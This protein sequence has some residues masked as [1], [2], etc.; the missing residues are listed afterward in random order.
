MILRQQ[1]EWDEYVGLFTTTVDAID[2]LTDNTEPWFDPTYYHNVGEPDN[3]EEATDWVTIGNLPDPTDGITTTAV[4]SGAGTYSASYEKKLTFTKNAIFK[5][6][7]LKH[8]LIAT[9][10][11]DLLCLLMEGNFLPQVCI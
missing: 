10:L 4:L 7:L 8:G 2:S 1:K 11:M 5:I 9:Q 3:V 6:E